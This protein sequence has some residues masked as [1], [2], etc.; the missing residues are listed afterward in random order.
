M[1]QFSDAYSNKK[2]KE[3]RASFEITGKKY[4]MKVCWSVRPPKALGTSVIPLHRESPRGKQLAREA[5]VS[6]E[7]RAPR[8]LP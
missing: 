8:Q 7:S 6:D 1:K 4:I 5:T 2:P 3:Q